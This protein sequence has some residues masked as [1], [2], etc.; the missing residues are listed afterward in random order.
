[1]PEWLSYSLN[2]AVVGISIVFGAL[3][4]ISVIIALVRRLEDRWHAHE[5]KDKAEALT[6]E[7][8]L[9]NTTLVLISA[10]VA[11]MIQGRF[12]I[13]K[14]RRLMP[15]DA[16]KGPWSVQ[17]RAILHGSHVSRRGR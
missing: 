3:V 2:F 17:G 7:P 12:H 4:I 15:R 10:A 5:T 13:R 14:V 8:T 6:K 16:M 9:D 11:T 1:M